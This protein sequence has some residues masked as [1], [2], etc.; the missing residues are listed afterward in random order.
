M[1]LRNSVHH[2]GVF[3]RRRIFDEF[4]FPAAMVVSGDYALNL[5]LFVCHRPSVSLDML[6]ARCARGGL[7]GRTL[8]IGYQEEKDIRSRLLP[9][10]VARLLDV[11]TDLR[12]MAKRLLV[13]I[14]SRRR[15]TSEW[16]GSGGRL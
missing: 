4:S 13:R 10:L 8:Y 16:H 15:P 11:L 6:M 1:W 3:Y 9:P 7:S 2:Q 14:R 5:W 12:Y